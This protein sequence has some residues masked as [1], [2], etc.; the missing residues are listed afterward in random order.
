MTKHKQIR[1]TLTAM[2]LDEFLGPNDKFDWLT[3]E[4]LTLL[5]Y[6]PLMHMLELGIQDKIHLWLTKSFN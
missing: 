4:K 2:T 5:L 1:G 6:S 3:E